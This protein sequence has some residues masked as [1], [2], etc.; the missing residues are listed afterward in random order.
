MSLCY[1][2]RIEGESHVF[3][4][5]S[6]VFDVRTKYQHAVCVDSILYGK[7]LFLDGASQSSEVDEYIYHEMLVHPVMSFTPPRSGLSVLI[8][9][10]GEGAT[11]R[12]VLKYREVSTV[13]M[14]DIDGELVDL[15]RKYMSEW[16]DDSVWSDPRVTLINDDIWN[17]FRKC[18]VKYD[19]VI[20]D[21]VDP[22]EDTDSTTNFYS[23]EFLE[24]IRDVMRGD[25]SQVVMQVGEYRPF[26]HGEVEK[27][28]LLFRKVFGSAESYKTF[29][30]VYQGE[31]AFIRTVNSSGLYRTGVIDGLRFY[32]SRKYEGS[33]IKSSIEINAIT[34]DIET[35]PEEK[36]AR[37]K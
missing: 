7:I 2:E 21:L 17:Y 31:W 14:V 26:D 13:T 33:I 4:I 20:V 23:I 1:V 8:I 27:M 12:E 29:V 15:C 6:V 19:V 3:D 25:D 5:N 9:G 18:A 30:P 16:A 35:C 11:L 24:S 32:T 10:G 34:K 37:S 28:S 36:I 22:D